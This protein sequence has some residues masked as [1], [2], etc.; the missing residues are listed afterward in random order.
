MDAVRFADQLERPAALAVSPDIT[1]KRS[2]L[3]ALKLLYSRWFSEGQR[4]GS[5]FDC[6][7]LDALDQLAHSKLRAE[8]ASPVLPYTSLKID[9]SDQ[10]RAREILEYWTRREFQLSVPLAAHAITWVKRLARANASLLSAGV[11][12]GFTDPSESQTLAQRIGSFGFRGS[13]VGELWG[14]APKLTPLVESLIS[15]AE[16]RE[17]MAAKHWVY[18]AVGRYTISKH[19]LWVINFGGTDA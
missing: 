16:T 2:V 17:F 15:C 5:A 4:E 7:V 11:C 8:P 14:V 3:A 12:E 13:H 9:W 6:A 10:R 18:A 1:D 19:T